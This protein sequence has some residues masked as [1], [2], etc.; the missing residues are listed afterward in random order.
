M[1]ILKV[2]FLSLIGLM[3]LFLIVA[4]FAP[5]SYKVERSVF[6][7]APKEVIMAQCKSLKATHEWSPWAEYDPHQKITYSGK[8]GEVGSSMHW[9]GNDSVGVGNQTIAKITD[10][11]VETKIEFI[12]PWTSTSDAYVQLEGKGEGQKVTWAFTGEDKYPMNGF[13]LFMNMDKMIGKDFER[14]L[15]KLKARC[16]I[17]SATPQRVAL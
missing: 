13:M 3:A 10:D 5:K 14:G 11:R 15:T 6:I 16:E 7:N 8:D 2:I 12:K 9:E 17:M 1:K 4:L